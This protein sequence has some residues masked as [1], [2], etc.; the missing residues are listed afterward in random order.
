V[1]VT[2]PPGARVTFDRPWTTRG[3]DQHVWLFEGRLEMTIGDTTHVLE[4]G[5]CL[6]MRLDRA[7]TYHNPTQHPIRYAVILMLEPPRV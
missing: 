3:S 5:D 2:F 1:D 6:H 4:A 7:I